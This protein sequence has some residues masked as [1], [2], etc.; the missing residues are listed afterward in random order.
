MSGSV[1]IH[2]PTPCHENWYTMTPDEQGRFCGSCQKAV[3]DFS[4]M[5]DKELLTY[6][7]S[8]SGYTACGRFSNEQLNRNIQTAE[9][10]GRYSWAYVWNVL[11]ASLLTTAVKAQSTVPDKR[12]VHGYIIQ[13]NT[14][15][16]LAYADVTI[17]GTSN[18]VLSDEK[19]EFKIMIEN[20]DSLILEVS[21]VGFEKYNLLINTNSYVQN[22]QIIMNETLRELMGM[23]VVVP[24][25]TVKQKVKRFFRRT[26]LAPF[27]KL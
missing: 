17:K 23:F 12:Q 4:T 9:R 22:V 7:S 6:I 5:T 26:L 19:G 13:S 3:V 27:R 25:Y 18:R 8:V 10:K 20:K 15:N 16:P 1:Q 24:H 21:Y 14:K 2:I 11:L